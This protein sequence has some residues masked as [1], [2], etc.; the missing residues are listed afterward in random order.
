MNNQDFP[1]FH[2]NEDLDYK[3]HRKPS[4]EEEQKTRKLV[5]VLA[6]MWAIVL[7]IIIISTIKSL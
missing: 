6:I 7:L 3:P 4:P 2:D 5:A 1:D